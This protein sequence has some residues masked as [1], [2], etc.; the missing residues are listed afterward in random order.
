MAPL[1]SF[2]ATFF[3]RKLVPDGAYETS[4]TE[5]PRYRTCSSNRAGIGRSISASA[6]AYGW[7]VWM[8]TLTSSRRSYTAACIDDSMDAFLAPRMCRPSSPS[9][10]MSPGSILP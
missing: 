2:F 5:R 6:L 10:Q 8:I 4:S 9:T 1:A 3:F 7:C